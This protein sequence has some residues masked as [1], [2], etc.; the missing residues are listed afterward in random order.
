MIWWAIGQML[1][2]VVMLAV[3]FCE[4]ESV[5]VLKSPAA[6]VSHICTYCSENWIGS[7]FEFCHSYH[8]I[9]G[10]EVSF[11]LGVLNP[12]GLWRL[13]LRV[14]LPRPWPEPQEFDV[15]AIIHNI[16]LRQ[17]YYNQCDSDKKETSYR[18]QLLTHQTQLFSLMT[19]LTST[20]HCLTS[21]NFAKW[22][23]QTILRGFVKITLP[24]LIDRHRKVTDSGW[25]YF[26]AAV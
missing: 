25:D 15:I 22:L 5:M 9:R 24:L 14:I 6:T 19:I 10:T 17:F 21:Q 18:G 3:L 20:K 23:S 26:N 2:Q 12:I 13:N 11:Y 7:L 16:E 1:S 8:K 4:G